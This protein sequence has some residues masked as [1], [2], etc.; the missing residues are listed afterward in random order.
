MGTPR[1]I[2]DFRRMKDR[3]R[4][5]GILK[6]KSFYK[7]MEKGKLAGDPD[8]QRSK[9]NHLKIRENFK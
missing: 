8:I 3:M 6:I 1:I 7:N 4:M 2:I 9:Y 5:C